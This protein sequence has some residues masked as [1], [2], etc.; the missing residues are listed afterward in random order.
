MRGGRGG[1]PGPE[2]GGPPPAD[3]PCRS[4][5]WLLSPKEAPHVRRTC[6]A[7]R[8][9]RAGHQPGQAEGWP[10]VRY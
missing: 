2:G 5:F 4:T 1:P 10:W 3:Q 7:F 6:C 9:A 8:P